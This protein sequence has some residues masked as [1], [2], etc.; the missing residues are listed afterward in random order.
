MIIPP[1]YHKVNGYQLYWIDRLPIRQNLRCT[2]KTRYRQKDVACEVISIND[3]CIEQRFDEPQLL[4]RL[5]Q[6]A[7]FIKARYVW[8]RCD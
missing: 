7:V 1:C 8:W 2:V 5:G 4:L 3:D 6:S